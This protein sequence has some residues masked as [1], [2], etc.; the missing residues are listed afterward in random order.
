MRID[1]NMFLDAL[2]PLFICAHWRPF[3]VLW[4]LLFPVLSALGVG[5]D[6]TVTNGNMAVT[7]WVAEATLDLAGARDLLGDPGEPEEI[8]VYDV[9]GA[10][11]LVPW[12]LDATAVT[13]VYTVAWRVPGAL[14]ANAARHFELRFEATNSPV[15]P[16]SVTIATNA[17]GIAV[18]NEE[19]SLFHNSGGLITEVSV[20]AASTWLNWN[21]LVNGGVGVFNLRYL[22]AD[23][24]T[25]SATGG[26]RVVVE[27][28]KEYHE[29]LGPG[30]YTNAPS[31][32][33]A[34]YRFTSFAGLPF[35]RIEADIT[36]DFAYSWDGVHF[37]WTFFN[38][39]FFTKYCTSEH[40]GTIMHTGSNYEGSRWSSV[41]NTNMMMA[42]CPG[43]STAV[44]DGGEGFFGSNLKSGSAPMI[45]LHY[46]WQGA[47]LFGE[48]AE[49]A[50]AIASYC[51]YWSAVIADPPVVEVYLS[52]AMSSLTNAEYEVQA[53]R[54][55]MGAMYGTNWLKEH[56]I[57]TIAG[58]YAVTARE[59]IESGLY[60]EAAVD[61][62]TCTNLLAVTPT[63]D[64]VEAGQLQA[65]LVEDYPCL[66]NSNAVYIW[67]TPSN[68]AGLVSVYDKQTEREFLANDVTQ[69]DWW[70]LSVKNSAGEGASC[71]N[72]DMTC[73][74]SYTADT[75]AAVLNMQWS[76]NVVVDV[77]AW[78]STTNGLLRATIAVQTNAPDTGLTMVTFPKLTDILPLS[79]GAQDD[80]VLETRDLGWRKPSPLVSSAASDT[81]YPNGMQFSALLDGSNGLYIAE[82]D[83]LVNRKNITW[84][85]D[86]DSLTIDLTVSHPVL[87]WGAAALT[88]TYQS[89]GDIVLGPFR[90]DWY[91]AARLYRK[92]ALTAPWCAKGPVHTRLDL[93]A[94][95]V[96]APY[97]TV[98]SLRD[99]FGVQSE[100]DKHAFYDMPVTI[101]HAYRYGSVLGMEESDRC[102]E[103]LPP[104]LNNQRFRSAVTNLQSEGVRI[105]PYINGYVWD[106]DTENYRNLNGSNA[107]VWLNAQGQLR[108]FTAYGGGQHL[109]GMCPAADLW[110]DHL[111]GITSNLFDRCG[112][113]GL[114]FDFLIFNVTD[115]YN[116]DH[117]HAIGGGNYWSGG[118]HDLLEG[119]R[120]VATNI[121]TNAIFATENVGEA[122][123]D[124]VDAFLSLGHTTT[125]APLFPAVY[126]GY[127]NVFG[128][129][130]NK[131]NP[132]YL[133]RW[134][135]MGGQNGWR[136]PE[137]PM[138][139]ITYYSGQDIS[140]F[141]NSGLYYKR[142]LDCRVAFATPYLG[143]GEML[144]PPDISGSLPTVS[145][146]G[147]Y[148]SLDVPVVEG[149]AWKAPDG[150]VGL[151]FLNY[152][153]DDAHEFIWS[154]DLAETGWDG[155][156]TNLVLSS[157]SESNGLQ[158][159]ESGLSGGD[160]Y[161]TS[162]LPAL[163]IMALKLEAAQ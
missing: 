42:V 32:P 38:D 51:D 118:V 114:Y 22:A 110:Q 56:V 150:R 39:E 29:Y 88:V 4:C 71:Q 161:R 41:F 123:I 30:Q 141:T 156:I 155:S 130:Q 72:G 142:L 119:C 127:A 158:V 86:H 91:D 117:G 49:T 100:L 120:A 138:A 85:P 16:Q 108:E 25:A 139:G 162:N 73:Q 44:Y 126:H 144:R 62:E 46:P 35:T 68:G 128:G 54:D 83:A 18:D 3:A 65:S 14:E 69:A 104:I 143:Y 131:Y 76:T 84:T 10:E 78:L 106:R 135:L 140:N 145:M 31:H 36:Q 43:N 111:K 134:W 74:V 37:I 15:D 154:V 89:P 102:G 17:G 152:D 96:N 153:E 47:L 109:M 58:R 121:N 116:E 50:A 27:T 148:G 57:T 1:S 90:G 151:F 98:A 132:E 137:L 40:S 157:W 124:V 87:N 48:G 95:F 11:G 82:E 5:I 146:T 33:R 149:S 34:T 163:G 159:V 75:S 77:Q 20:G 63:A 133:G 99:E 13:G 81:A 105:V 112:I 52:E 67:S 7:N 122:Y 21:D 101:A 19:I 70:D 79:P 53:R 92:W 12:Q 136:G 60:E 115:C 2:K 59:K 160:L 45:G 64:I 28:S 6:L 103:Y 125:T 55:A 107:V 61:L 9:D 26:L 147:P 94:W 93:P 66:A 8:A 97:W 24:L 113:D 23:S 129:D 80:E